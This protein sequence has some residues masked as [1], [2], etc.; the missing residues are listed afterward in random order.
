MQFSVLRAF[1]VCIFGSLVLLV[2][3]LNGCLFLGNKNEIKD[4]IHVNEAMIHAHCYPEVTVSRTNASNLTLLLSWNDFEASLCSW[5]KYVE[6]GKF[7]KYS[8]LCR[9]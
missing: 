4:I 6:Y 1:L 3:I 5:N 7:N 2:T 9:K 8:L